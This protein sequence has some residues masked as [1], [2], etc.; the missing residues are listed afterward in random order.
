MRE[1]EGDP[2]AVRAAHGGHPV[3]APRVVQDHPTGGARPAVVPAGEGV[4][5]AQLPD[6]VRMRHQ[7]V[8]DAEPVCAAGR[9]HP[10]EIAVLVEGQPC[11]GTVAV[12]ASG[13][14]VKHGLAPA[15]AGVGQLVGDAA[16]LLDAASAGPTDD[17]GPVQV[18]SAVQRD[19]PVR[20]S[21]V[22]AA[23]EAVEDGMGPSGG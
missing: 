19:A 9:R 11:P 4:D 8:D 3:E 5:H 23:R 21:P 16:P 14:V 20:L 15:P 1:P 17:R 18:P 2:L 6:A 22:R 12:I 7:L 10:V 13:E